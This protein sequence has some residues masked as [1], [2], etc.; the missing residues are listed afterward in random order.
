ML[1][2]LVAPVSSSLSND[3]W[4]APPLG[5]YAILSVPASVIA[6]LVLKILMPAATNLILPVAR[7][8]TCENSDFIGCVQ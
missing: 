1:F 2:E 3:D 4:A 5:L 8:S 6:V 7:G